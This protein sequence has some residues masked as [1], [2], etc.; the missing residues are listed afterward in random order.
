[1]FFRLWLRIECYCQE[2]LFLFS[3]IARALFDIEQDY[4][5]CTS[6]SNPMTYSLRDS[7]KHV[8]PPIVRNYPQ[9]LGKRGKSA[10]REPT[11]RT[12]R[13]YLP[14][15]SLTREGSS[16]KGTLV[17]TAASERSWKKSQFKKDSMLIMIIALF[18]ESESYFEQNNHNNTI[19]MSAV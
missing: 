16:G 11:P 10:P 17:P 18:V 9:D 1:M 8:L 6:H 2:K 5:I 15:S 12:R 13:P 3:Y 4:I 7:G 14:L 19:W